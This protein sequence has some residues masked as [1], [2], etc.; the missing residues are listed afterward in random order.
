MQKLL[1]LSDF[2]LQKL[3]MVNRQIN[4]SNPIL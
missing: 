4:N 3:N 2:K 1:G